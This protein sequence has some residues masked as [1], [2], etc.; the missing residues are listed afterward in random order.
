MRTK[1]TIRKSFEKNTEGEYCR[2]AHKLHLEVLLDI[3]EL[4][5][6]LDIYSELMRHERRL[7]KL[8]RKIEGLRK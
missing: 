1:E 3:R 5:K 8:E 6:K 2:N 4:L 7:Q